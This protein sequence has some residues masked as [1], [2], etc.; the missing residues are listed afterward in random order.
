MGIME[1]AAMRNNIYRLQVTRI[2]TLGLPKDPVE[3]NNPWKPDGQ[4]PDELGLELE[5]NL[6][7]SDWV[8]RDFVHE[9]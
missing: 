6:K 7:V 2:S 3:E 4:T 1:F 5:V 8:V 9:I